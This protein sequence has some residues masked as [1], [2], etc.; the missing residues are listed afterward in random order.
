M[1][2]DKATLSVNG[3]PQAARIARLLSG[4]GVRVTCVGKV[5]L[6]S[7]SFIQDPPNC[8]GPLEALCAF[9]P[10]ADS[11][12]VASCDMPA[13][14]PRVVPLLAAALGN[15]DCSLVAVGDRWQPYCAIY[16]AQAHAKLRVAVA[17]GE[18]SIMRVLQG[19]TVSIVDERALLAE[20]ISTAAV[21]GANTPTEF[22]ALTD[23]ASSLTNASGL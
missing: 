8:E 6:G 23:K 17:A 22:A 9:F 10:R 11:V 21:T 20:G 5:P 16:T 13:F 2:V 18:R 12:F 3:E 14:D 7:Y 4:E 19:M 15:N 1:G